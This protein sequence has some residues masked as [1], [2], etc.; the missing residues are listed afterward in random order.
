MAEE[1]DFR[2]LVQRI[3]ARD[4]EAARILVQHYQEE[5][6]RAIH[7]RLTDP[8]LRRVLDSMDICNSVMGHFFVRVEAGQY[9][10]DDPRDLLKLLVK[11]A[12]HKL[13]EKA[14]HEYAQRRSPR[15]L[16]EVESGELNQLA[17]KEETPSQ[18]VAANEL[19][20]RVRERLSDQERY[21]AEQRALGREWA[22]LAEEL[23]DTPDALRKRLDRALD[24]V[25]KQLELETIH[26]E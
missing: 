21:L 8:R 2:E 17:A 13:I 26:I 1:F 11:M 24:R 16:Q 25:V 19:L 12:Q 3:R 18:I 7:F 20:Q 14:R 6:R 4:S 15:R 10:F 9:H 22:S 5:I 23:N